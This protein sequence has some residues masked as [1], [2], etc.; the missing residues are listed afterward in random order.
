MPFIVKFMHDLFVV[1][2]LRFGELEKD[3]QDTLVS[4]VKLGKRSKFGLWA[5]GHWCE[6]QHVKPRSNIS[7][8]NKLLRSAN[9]C[10]D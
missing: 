1:I 8:S 9:D 2:S 5:F 10:T 7:R 4:V 3:A 6:E